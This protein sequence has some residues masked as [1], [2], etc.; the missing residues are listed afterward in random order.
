MKKLS[1]LLIGLFSG[2]A[3]FAQSKTAEEIVQQLTLEEKVNLVVGMGM[4]LPGMNMSSGTGVGQIT[5]GVPGAAGTTYSIARL[6]L[7]N[8]IVSDGPAGLRIDPKRKDDKNTYYATAWPVAT[9]L[10]STW[11][12]KLIQQVGT[13]MGNEVKEYG[14]DVILG[15]GMNIH[16]NPLGGR[17]FEYYSEDPVVSGKMAASIIKGIQS[18][19]VGVSIKHFA[20]NNQ[21]KNRNTVNAIISE[22]A[23]REIYLKGF[24]IAVKEADPWT[25]MSSYNYINGTY[26]SE[27]YDLLTTVL[28]KEWGFKGLVMTDWFGGKDAVAQ[29]KAGNDLLMPGTKDQKKAITDAINNGSL[30]IKILDANAERIVNY[31]LGTHTYKKDAFSNKPDL[32]AHA[33]IARNAAADGMVLLKNNAALPVSKSTKNIAA[34]G[35]TSYDFVSGGTGSGD[36]N[37]EYTI[38]LVQGLSNAGYTLDESLTAA[39][40]TYVTAEKAKQPKKNFFEEFMNP[41]PRIT[42]MMVDNNVLNTQASAAGVA[43]ITIGRNAGEGSDRKVENDFNL[44]QSEIDLINNVSKAFHTKNK[45]V[46]VIINAGGVIETASWR[47]KVDAVLMTWQPGLE[48]G[49]AVA[50][51]LSGKV[52]PS[53]KLATTFPVK[54]ED[55]ITAKNFPGIEF[56]EKAT[57]GMMGMKAIPAEVTYEEGVYVG[58]RYYNTFKVKPAYAFG[59]GLSY[60]NFEYSNLKLSSPSFNGKVIATVDVKNTGKVAGKE[61]VQLYI[62]APSKKLQKPA[63]ELKAFGKTNLLQ[64]GQKQTLQFEIA[65]K[66]LASFDTESTSWVTDAGTYFVK[67]GSSSDKIIKTVSFTVPKEIVVEKCNKVLMPQVQINELKK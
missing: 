14:I 21:E 17:N 58:Y 22:R 49:N 39:Y 43:L 28:R 38:S 31:I 42:E 4:N 61:V 47:D 15:P 51:I 34:F 67:V 1:F 64:L 6:N 26:T 11:D 45:K 12:T 24:E 30:D 59:Y 60:T 16:R 57:T 37:E 53:G 20:F 9:L 52:N 41:T 13:A 23:A 10:A 29:M 36:V 27:S 18:N 33:A 40:Q 48:A 25:V 44:K 46:I 54:Y 62:T 56:P 32:K 2:I 7:P 8:T 66:D 5:D 50:D 19:G 55:D 65:A 63:M 3:V 35:I